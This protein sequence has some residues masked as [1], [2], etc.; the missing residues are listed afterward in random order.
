MSPDPQEIKKMAA[1]F[2]ALANPNRLRLYLEIVERQ[3]QRIHARGKCYLSDIVRGLS[4]GS[5]TVSH[6]VRELARAELISTERIGKQLA[7]SANPATRR[8]LLAFLKNKPQG[9][10]R[11]PR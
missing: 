1:V 5:P 9:A 2:Q 10:L 6:H 4:V 11:L 7:C 3:E 8:R